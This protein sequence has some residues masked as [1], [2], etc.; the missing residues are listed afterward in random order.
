MIYFSNI[1]N[2]K[3]KKER[4]AYPYNI[5]ALRNLTELEFTNPITL[6]RW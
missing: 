1:T 2:L 3:R 4:K 5:K 6:Y